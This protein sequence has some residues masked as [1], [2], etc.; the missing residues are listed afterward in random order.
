MSL[1][2]ADKLQLR[3]C[4]QMHKNA[5]CTAQCCGDPDVWQGDR[6]HRSRRSSSV[7]Y[8]SLLSLRTWRL[9]GEKL[10]NCLVNLVGMVHYLQSVSFSDFGRFLCK[11]VCG[12]CSCEFSR[13]HSELR[14]FSI[15]CQCST[16]CISARARSSCTCTHSMGI[17]TQRSPI[18]AS[19]PYSI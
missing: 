10:C 9:I 1:V 18:L 17:H 5:E 19:L 14:H 4:Q 11:S 15:L 6:R 7:S 3:C 12:R 16:L 8:I 2:R 13:S